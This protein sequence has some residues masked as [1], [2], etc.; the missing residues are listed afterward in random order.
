MS[1]EVEFTEDKYAY[2]P[3]RKVEPVF[4]HVD[5]EGAFMYLL[6]GR[7][8]NG[9]RIWNDGITRFQVVEL[10]CPEGDPYI[11]INL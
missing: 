8:M 10:G 2:P 5:V 1:K 6:D 9:T 3:T 7:T 4:D 11:F